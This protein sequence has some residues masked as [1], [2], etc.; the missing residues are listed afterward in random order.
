[1]FSQRRVA[2]ES[3]GM[4]RPQTEPGR[5]RAQMISDDVK[6][7]TRQSVHDVTG[8][9]GGSGPEKKEPEEDWVLLEK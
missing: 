4:T 5:T 6:N 8:A 3:S 7:L 2:P 9:S 1:M